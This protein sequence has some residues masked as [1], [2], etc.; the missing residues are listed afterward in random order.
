M[1]NQNNRHLVPLVADVVI[2]LF[3]HPAQQPWKSNA[4]GPF[5]Y[6]IYMLVRNSVRRSFL[7]RRFSEQ[8]ASPLQTAFQRDDEEEEDSKRY[9]LQKNPVIPKVQNLPRRWLKMDAGQ[10]D[11]V[12]AYLEDKMRGDWHEL[13]A[14]E[15]RALHYIYYGSWGPR[16]SEHVDHGRIYGYF[17]WT[18]GV[19]L[20]G[21]TSYKAWLGLDESNNTE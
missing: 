5:A 7:I 9:R 18:I 1:L 3:L 15:K 2:F 11:D 8:K 14:D 13:T 20:A 10:Q 4:R 16:G 17:A 21:V 12:I 6:Y 19:S